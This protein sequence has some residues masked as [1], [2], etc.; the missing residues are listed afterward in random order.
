METQGLKK[1]PVCGS[2]NWDQDHTCGVCGGDLAEPVPVDKVSLDQPTAPIATP[3]QHKLK[4]LLLVITGPVLSILGLMLFLNLF[5]LGSLVAVLG[6]GISLFGLFITISVIGAGP[7]RLG[8]SPRESGGRRGGGEFP[9]PPMWE[10][11]RRL[12]EDDQARLKEKYSSYAPRR[13]ETK[14]QQAQSS[15]KERDEEYQKSE[16]KNG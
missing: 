1:C 6:I 2:V 14:A 5:N 15:A 3:Y 11:H 8:R 7:S 10:E 16:K 9:S 13:G 4:A 12:W